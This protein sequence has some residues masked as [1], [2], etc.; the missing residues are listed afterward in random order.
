MSVSYPD[1]A[2]AVRPRR[3]RCDVWPDP[4]GWIVK[5]ESVLGFS[6][7]APGK[8]P[9]FLIA[10]GRSEPEEEETM[11]CCDGDCRPLGWLLGLPFALL[12]VLVSLVGAII[13]I[14]GLIKK[15]GWCRLPISC[16][17]PCCLCVTV[18]LEVAVELVKAPLHVMTWFTSKIPC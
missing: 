1:L 5:R 15:I 7:R 6:P 3:P 13:W 14:I 12:A 10:S 11:C 16:I 9:K 18:L 4:D 17:C 8:R 2:V